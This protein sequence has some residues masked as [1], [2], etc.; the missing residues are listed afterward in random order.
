MLQGDASLQPD[1]RTMELRDF[2]AALFA[3]S[4]LVVTFAQ[5]TNR[6]PSVGAARCQSCCA[7]RST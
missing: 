2:H 4:V 5:R 1:Q 7:A 6:A 3:V